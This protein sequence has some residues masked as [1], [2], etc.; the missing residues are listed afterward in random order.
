MR[1]NLVKDGLYE[2]EYYFG[3][4]G[5]QVSYYK[6][7]W[8]NDAKKYFPCFHETFKVFE[9]LELFEKSMREKGFLSIKEM[10]ERGTLRKT[11]WFTIFGSKVFIK[12]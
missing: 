11:N 6:Y 12:I 2:R 8:D 1:M 4:K 9:G 5:N 3:R 7:K 10:E